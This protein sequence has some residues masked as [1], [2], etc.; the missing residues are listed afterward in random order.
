[1]DD[2]G[3]YQ[4]EVMEE[5]LHECNEYADNYQR[6]EEDGWFYSDED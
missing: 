3:S 6:S 2:N 1:M 5:I 4:T